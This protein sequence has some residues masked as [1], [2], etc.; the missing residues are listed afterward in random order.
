MPRAGSRCCPDAV[1]ARPHGAEER[2]TRAGAGQRAGGAGG[3]PEAVPGEPRQPAPSSAP[4]R[5]PHGAPRALSRPAERPAP[6]PAP[7]PPRLRAGPAPRPRP[8]PARAR[9][10]P[11]RAASWGRSAC[12]AV[13]GEGVLG[14]YRLPRAAR[15]PR[16]AGELSDAVTASSGAETGKL[17]PREVR[18][19]AQGHPASGPGRRA[20]RSAPGAG[21]GAGRD[22]GPGGE[23]GPPPR[24]LR[25]AAGRPSCSVRLP[26]LP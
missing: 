3:E 22:R 1:P 12:A 15:Q 13:L 23:P 25:T 10:S 18:R 26:G 11:R 21:A 4:T 9:P 17:R 20:A 24:A 7:R 16:A 5:T 8:A 6:P 2:R 19:L 14:A